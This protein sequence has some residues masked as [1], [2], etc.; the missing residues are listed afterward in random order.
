MSDLKIKP[1][2]ADKVIG[3]NNSS[4]PLGKRNDLHLLYENAK[5]TNNKG[6]LAMFE[7]PVTEAVLDKTKSDSFLQRM[8]ERLHIKLDE[9][10]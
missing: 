8:E 9:F 5:I 3:F 6:H 1:E 4:L 10:K 2:F 7:E